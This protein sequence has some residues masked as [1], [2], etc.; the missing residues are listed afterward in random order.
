MPNWKLIAK[1]LGFL[2]YIEAGL[3]M[4]CQVVCWI[5]HEGVL[6]FALPIG[7]ALVLGTTGVLL[8]RNAGK[9]M[10]RKDGY[11]VVSTVWIISPSSA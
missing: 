11:I 9:K 5:Y 1:I 2:L 6:A 7:I 10:G 4:L 3:M 8:G